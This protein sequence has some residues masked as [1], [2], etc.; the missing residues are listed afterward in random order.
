LRVE[1]GGHTLRLVTVGA[2]T[3]QSAMAQDLR[4]N[5]SGG[6]RDGELLRR[7][8]Q[9]RDPRVREQ[10]VHRYL[11]LA[12]YAA[13]QYARGTEAFDDLF[14]VASVGLLKALD[15][16]DPARGAAFSS[17]ALP[18][19]AGELRRH[20]R[21]R[22]WAVRP[23][24]DLQEHALAVERAGAELARSLGRSPTVAE[25]AAHAGFDEETVLEA[26]E[27]LSAR[28]SA[29]LSAPSRNGDDGDQTLEA[30]LGADDGGFREAEHRVTL[31]AL[32]HV[33]T[34]REREVVRL[35]FDEDLTQAEIGQVVGLSQMH[36]S[37]VLRAALEKLRLA[38]GTPSPVGMSS[39]SPDAGA[40]PAH[41]AASPVASPCAGRRARRTGG[42]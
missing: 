16:Y 24:R 5:G 18:T 22:G 12:R 4:A 31:E 29:S 39:R 34:P 19:M 15:R 33:L 23:P 14:Q 1:A 9:S 6:R 8:A 30:R 11:P 38:A 28:M 3:R 37:R 35:R 25:I 7:F 20:F 21:D 13:S 40:V 17:Y 36:V 41:P 10:L 42:P 2:A 32:S 27:A 26:R